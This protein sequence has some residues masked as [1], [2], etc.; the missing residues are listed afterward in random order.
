MF[1]L[2]SNETYLNSTNY[3]RLQMIQNE[4]KMSTAL[5][6]ER[7]QVTSKV[8]TKDILRRE[9]NAGDDMNISALA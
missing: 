8:E 9:S 1:R 7:L 3:D 4:P 6:R 2:V 5:L